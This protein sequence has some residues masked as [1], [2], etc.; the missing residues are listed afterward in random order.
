[1]VRIKKESKAIYINLAKDIYEQLEKFCEDSG[2]SKTTAV[3]RFIKT[4][5]EEY[6]EKK[7]EKHSSNF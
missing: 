2:Q 7:N 5:V 1:M 3:E 6:F 4:G